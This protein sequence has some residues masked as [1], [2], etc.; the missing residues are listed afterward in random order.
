MNF[1]PTE[2][3]ENLNPDSKTYSPARLVNQKRYKVLKALTMNSIPKKQEDFPLKEKTNTQEKIKTQ[4]KQREE[5][6]DQMKPLKFV[7]EG[8]KTY[9]I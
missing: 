6:I 9:G 2:D 7:E 1:F 5:T 8:K 4:E 3:K